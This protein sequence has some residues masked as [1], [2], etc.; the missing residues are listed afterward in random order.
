MLLVERNQS[1]PVVL[2]VILDIDDTEMRYICR[3]VIHS[4][5]RD[6]NGNG[7]GHLT[8]FFSSRIYCDGFQHAVWFTA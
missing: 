8:V 5:V 4:V 1:L 2:I 3:H 6:G 7:L